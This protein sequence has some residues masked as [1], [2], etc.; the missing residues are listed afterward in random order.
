MTYK[1]IFAASSAAVLGLLAAFPVVA[2]TPSP[3][4]AQ[5]AATAFPDANV[6]CPNGAL[7]NFSGTIYDFAGGHA[8][9]V[10]TGRALHA[11]QAVDD[12]AIVQ[13]PS[14]AT[15][16]ISPVR[17]GTVI[18]T[19]AVT[20]SPTIYVMGT[21]GDLHGFSTPQ[22]LIRA[23]YDDALNV[24][25]PNLAGLTVGSTAGVAGS[26]VTAL[27]TSADG[28][29]INSSGAFYV[30]AGGTAFGVPSTRS[31]LA[32]LRVT[33]PAAMLSGTLPT[34]LSSGAPADGVLVTA[35]GG[36]YVSYHGEL[37]AFRS[38][39]QLMAD[40]YGGTASNSVPTVNGIAT[41]TAYTGS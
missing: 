22:Q 20:G 36:V 27:A 33:N 38:M 15:V 30:L 32:A 11:L 13:A 29:I 3:A 6:T 24:T 37:W 12:A 17:S 21:D 41:V 34:T 23:G 5:P 7:V 26:S 10:P 25:V 9:D 1:S 31:A 40:G 14:G 2:G 18:T 39:E 8:F 28:A 19:S 35:N 4:M 16:P